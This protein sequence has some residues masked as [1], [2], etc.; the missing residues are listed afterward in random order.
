VP[1]LSTLRLLF[2]DTAVVKP[3]TNEYIASR[4]L[5]PLGKSMIQSPIDVVTPIISLSEHAGAIVSFRDYLGPGKLEEFEQSYNQ[6][7]NTTTTKKKTMFASGRSRDV[8]ECTLDSDA[9]RNKKVVVLATSSSPSETE[10]DEF[11]SLRVGSHGFPFPNSTIAIVDPETT[12]LCPSD[13][14]GEIWIDAPSLP[15]GFWGIPALTDAVYH[16]SPVLV[17]SETLYPEPYDQKFVRTGFL[18]TMIGGRLVVLGLYED[19]IRQQ[20]LGSELGIEETHFSTDIFNTL[21]KKSRI[22]SW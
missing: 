20:R 11:G 22:D 16:G 13:T 1:D 19:R 6:E 2:I 18:G 4:L 9:L 15:D 10:M 17:P 8:W 7:D 12:L 21:T 5:K 14:I 3:D